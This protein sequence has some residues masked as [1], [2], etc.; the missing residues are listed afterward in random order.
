MVICVPCDLICPF[1]DYSHLNYWNRNPVSTNFLLQQKIQINLQGEAN[2]ESSKCRDLFKKPRIP[3]SKEI[4]L[5]R[6]SKN[7]KL[8]QR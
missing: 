5:F 3:S 2:R 6:S 4:S 1:S 8:I 7:D